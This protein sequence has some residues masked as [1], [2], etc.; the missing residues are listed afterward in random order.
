M[1]NRRIL[2]VLGQVDDKY[3]EEA[4]PAGRTV[5]R[6]V[7]TKWAAAAACLC[8]II[9][10]AVI[11]SNRDTTVVYNSGITVSEDGVTIPPKQ[12]TLSVADNVDADMI[13]FFIYQG[14]C[15]V[16][17]EWIFDE[18]D[19]IGE[20]LG[21]ATGMID[22]WTP[23]EGYVELA[24]SV[25]GD[26]YSVNGFDPA[27]MLCMRRENGAVE[28]YINDSGLTLKTGADLFEDLLHLSDN[29]VEVQ[30]ETRNS[31]YNS[32]NNVFTVK[33]EYS[34][35][36][37]SFVAAL[38]DAPFMRTEDIPLSE[39]QDNIYDAL[40]IYHMYF[41]TD[42]GVTI[43]LRLF[44][45]GYV[46]FQGIIG[47][48]VKVD[49]ESFQALI[50]LLEDENASLSA[51]RTEASLTYDDCLDD[52]YFGKFVPSYIPDGVSFES[53]E[54]HYNIEQ[55]TGELCGTKEMWIYYSGDVEYSIY[56]SWADS[57][58]DNGWAGT[59]LYPD[60]LT[61][62]AVQEYIDTVWASGSPRV[63]S[64]VYF[65]LW[66]GDVMVVLNGY[67]LDAQTACDIMASVSY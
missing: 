67:G 35:A 7:W 25:R 55:E 13:G 11:F 15:Y 23:N 38:D 28:I 8:L 3:I 22:E 1:E 40:E 5:K 43:H 44:E 39:G 32:M 6:R 10:G 45:G 62:E 53:A 50:D 16:Q 36:V 34:D 42:S 33:S 9:F 48:C 60:E 64:K 49:D 4:A 46:R 61:P 18:V 56:I 27:F 14:R 57:Y 30:F 20:Y 26:F 19:V 37:R 59:M 29:Y 24:G 2:N 21:T 65:G 12:V 63:P 17:Y 47:A 52:E 31:W 41:L 58:E 66:V 51:D 54:K